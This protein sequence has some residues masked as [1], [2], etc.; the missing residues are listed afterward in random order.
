MIDWVLHHVCQPPTA[1][2]QLLQALTEKR[3]PERLENEPG[4][5]QTCM[6]PVCVHS[7]RTCSQ[8]L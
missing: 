2:E 7:P 8:P 1:V 4:V 6:W 5:S 3:R